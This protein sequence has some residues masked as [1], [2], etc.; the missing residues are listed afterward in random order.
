MADE[1]SRPLAH[2]STVENEIEQPAPVSVSAHDRLAAARE[3]LNLEA[4]HE[5]GIGSPYSSL[6]PAHKAH[7]AAIEHLIEVEAEHLAA[8]KALA[9]AHA[10]VERAMARVEETEQASNAVEH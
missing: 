7:L 9:I 6:H 1:D 4:G 2:L 10:R 8:E 5:R 3:K